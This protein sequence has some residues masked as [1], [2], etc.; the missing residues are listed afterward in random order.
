MYTV[1]VKT[2]FSLF[3]KTIKCQGDGVLN[4]FRWFQTPD[5]AVIEYP[6]GNLKWVKLSKY[7]AKF[8]SD[9]DISGGK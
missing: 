3:S 7:R 8:V 5:L 2:K 1:K 6:I 9:K 4:G